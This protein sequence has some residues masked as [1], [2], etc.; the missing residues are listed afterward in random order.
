MYLLLLYGFI[1]NFKYAIASKQSYKIAGILPKINY[2]NEYNQ[3]FKGDNAKWIDSLYAI[4]FA[5]EHFKHYFKSYY[6]CNIDFDIRYI[7]V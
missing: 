7:K 2:F 4:Q 5:Q 3:C 1:F 6:N